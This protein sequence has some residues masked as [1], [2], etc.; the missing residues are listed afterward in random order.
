MQVI[1][2]QRVAGRGEKGQVKE[3]ADGY[4]RN[5]LI[6]RGLATAATPEKLKALEAKNRER[7]R[8]EIETAKRLEDFA[9]GLEGKA[10]AFPLKTDEHGSVF[11]SVKKETLE[12]AIRELGLHPEDKVEA[13]LPH[14]LKTFGEHLV[15]VRLGK[16]I[17]AE[18]K[19]S[20]QPQP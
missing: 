1:F 18:V 10:L 14:P 2:L 5:F 15:R 6:P 4:A 20:V 7:T 11:G 9:K 16:G 13:E 8:E 3:I 19:V 12:K 17:E